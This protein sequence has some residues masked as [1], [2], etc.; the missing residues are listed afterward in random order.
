MNNN[1]VYVGQDVD[2]IQYRPLVRLLI[3]RLL[4]YTFAGLVIGFKVGIFTIGSQS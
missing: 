4:L 3:E 1:I 2:D